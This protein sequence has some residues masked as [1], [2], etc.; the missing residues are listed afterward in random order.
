MGRY[1]QRSVVCGLVPCEGHINKYDECDR[2]SSSLSSHLTNN[3]INYK[4]MITFKLGRLETGD[5]TTRSP[6]GT[7]ITTES[8]DKD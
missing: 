6:E 5:H 3:I 1:L 7:N 8:P 2:H 4:T